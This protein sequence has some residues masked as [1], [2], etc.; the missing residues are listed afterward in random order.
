MSRIHISIPVRDLDRSVDFY[1]R[2]FGTGPSKRRDDYANFRLDEPP[3]HLAMVSSDTPPAPSGPQHFGVELPSACALNTWR[4]RTTERQ[5]DA[6]EEPD[7]H[8]CYARADKLW[9]TDPD[10]H[11]WE[12]W[13]R[14]GEHDGLG[15]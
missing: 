15:A 7:A 11:R 1:G 5:L 14:T 13:V 4:Q 8:C 3:I 12:I 9:L 6:E 10:G 2:L